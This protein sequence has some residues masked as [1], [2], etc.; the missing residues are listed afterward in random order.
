MISIICRIQKAK[1]I[2]KQKRRRKKQRDKKPPVFPDKEPTG[3]CQRQE[4]EGGWAKWV[5]GSRRHRL[6]VMEQISYED[7]R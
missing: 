2:N 6:P 1:Q 3:G 4:R 5:K 7:K